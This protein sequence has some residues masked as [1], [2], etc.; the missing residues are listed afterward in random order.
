MRATVQAL[1]SAA[2]PAGGDA[3]DTVY[4][5]VSAAVMAVLAAAVCVLAFIAWRLRRRG[6]RCRQRAHTSLTNS[7]NN[8]TAAEPG[9]TDRSGSTSVR[10]ARLAASLLHAADPLP[11]VSI[12]P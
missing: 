8:G 6:R 5:G 10:C 12:R 3:D 4:I 2:P 7:E 9:S 1:L 11:R